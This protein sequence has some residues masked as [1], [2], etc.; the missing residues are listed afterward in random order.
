MRAGMSA[1]NALTALAARME[2]ASTS[3]FIAFPFVSE[4]KSSEAKS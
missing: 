1:A 2:A 3:F 4:I